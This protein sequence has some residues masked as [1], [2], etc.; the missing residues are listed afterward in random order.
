[1]KLFVNSMV[2]RIAEWYIVH[3]SMTWLATFLLFNYFIFFHSSS[4]PSWVSGDVMDYWWNMK[5]CFLMKENYSLLNHKMLTGKKWFC[6]TNEVKMKY[7]HFR[8]CASY[9]LLPCFSCSVV[10]MPEDCRTMKRCVAL[11][12]DFWHV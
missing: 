1:M 4:F 2:Y 10:H 9:I 3:M 6:P 5:I 12:T 11:C 8:L 7:V